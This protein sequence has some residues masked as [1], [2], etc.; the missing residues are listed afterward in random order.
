M[1]QWHPVGQFRPSDPAAVVI[2]SMSCSRSRA[3]RHPLLD[4]RPVVRTLLGKQRSP[5]SCPSISSLPDRHLAYK[6]MPSAGGAA[7]PRP[8]RPWHWLRSPWSRAGLSWRRWSR[9]WP[10][11]LGERLPGELGGGASA[12]GRARLC[13]RCRA[14][15][16]VQPFG[17]GAGCGGLGGLLLGFAEF[18]DGFGECG[19]PGQR[20]EVP[21]AVWP[22]RGFEA[23]GMSPARDDA[24]IG[25]FLPAAGTEQVVQQRFDVLPARGAD[26]PDHPITVVVAVTVTEG[27]C[28]PRRRLRRCGRRGACSRPLSGEALRQAARW[29]SAWRLPGSSWW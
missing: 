20:G 7:W 17:G 12:L 24:G 29:R 26:L 6:E 3:I 11:W 28:V 19:Q 2:T 1:G 8:W 23:G 22:Q 27:L 18:G 14:C 4:L 16:G 9:S 15:G 13:G 10:G 21:L 5:R 25:V